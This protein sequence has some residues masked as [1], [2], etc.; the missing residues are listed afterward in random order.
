M[1]GNDG[2]K[3]VA[4][5]AVGIAGGL[6]LAAILKAKPAAAAPDSQKLDYIASLLE[7][8]GA[9]QEAILTAIKSISLPGGG[10]ITFPDSFLTP[11]KAKEPEHIFEQAIRSIGVFQSDQMVDYRNG[12]RLLIK[13]ESTLDQNVTIQ[14]VGNYTESFNL[15]TN[16]NGPFVVLPNGNI[17][18]GL[19]WD[20]WHPYVGVQITTLIAPVAGILNIWSVMQE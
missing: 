3:N 6:S 1:A 17:T 12:K 18:I 15:A 2:G 14:L 11:W 5:V 7:H 9:T 13:V 19:A 8:M 16:I 10:I 20:D 4:L